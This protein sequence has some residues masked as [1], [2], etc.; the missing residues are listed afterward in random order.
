[1]RISTLDS[2]SFYTRMENREHFVSAE[3]NTDNNIF[4]LLT[5]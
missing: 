5:L 1:M 3:K 4:E 2:L